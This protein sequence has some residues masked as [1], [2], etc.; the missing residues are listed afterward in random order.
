M[1]VG[2]SEVLF[3]KY[4][5]NA[6][7][8]KTGSVHLPFSLLWTVTAIKGFSYP[9]LPLLIKFS[10]FGCPSDAQIQILESLS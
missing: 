6:R 3:L 4:L 2:K 10:Q 1:A 5:A 7:M 8:K 9:L